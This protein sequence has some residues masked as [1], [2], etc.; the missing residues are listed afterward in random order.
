[1]TTTA[2]RRPVVPSWPREKLLMG[3]SLREYLRSLATPFNAVAGLILLIGLPV[4]AYRFI[5]GLGAVTNLSQANPWGIWI[6][7]DVLAGVALAAGGYVLAGTVY[8]F[9]LKEYRPVVRPAILTGFLG[10]FFVVVGLLVDLGQPWRLPYPIVFSY[11]VTSV[12]F[13]VAWCV[14]LYF[15]VLSLEFSPTV[16]EWLGWE[17]ARRWASRITIGL[18]VSGVVLSILHQSSLGALFLMAPTK[19][20]PLWYSPFIPLY[21]F[22]SSII[23]GLSM[24]IVETGLSHRIFQDQLR[25]QAHADIGAI[26]LGLGK[27]ASVVLFSYFFMKLLGIA[28]GGN[29]KL[30]NTPYGYWFLV[31]LLGFILLPCFLF[32]HGARERSVKLVRAAAAMTVVGVV[33][34]RLNI[35]VIAFNWAGPERYV[36]SWMELTVTLTIVTL[37]LLTFRWIVNRMPVLREHPARRGAH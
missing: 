31:E 35:S 28:D 23:A 5:F 22:V 14:L 34:N 15:T 1:M 13:E 6:G 16:F 36:P 29:W 19:I 9:G 26:T 24:V 32:A 18:V 33:V 17:K 20:H 30:L 8:L 27:A 4:I 7:F 21:F 37:G 3:L 25:G 2:E 12:M 11:G 10:Y